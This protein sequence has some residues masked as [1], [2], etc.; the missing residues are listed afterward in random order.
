MYDHV[1]YDALNPLDFL[2]RSASVYAN[3]PAVVYRDTQ[4]TYGEF[5]ARV[6]RL[7]GSCTSGARLGLERTA[8]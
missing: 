8:A 1:W 7:A 3:K 2:E 4:Y 5:H 6:N